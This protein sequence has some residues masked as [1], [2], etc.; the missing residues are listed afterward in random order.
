MSYP[1]N[2][3]TFRVLSIQERAHKLLRY[4]QGI[5]DA[6]NEAD[7]TQWSAYCF[8]WRPKELTARLSTLYHRPEN[9]LTSSGH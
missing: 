5:T 6:W 8:R 3:A 2:L 7:G 1:T 4:D 9:C